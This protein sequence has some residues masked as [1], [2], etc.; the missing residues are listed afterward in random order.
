MIQ[1][2]EEGLLEEREGLEAIAAGFG[3]SLRQLRRIVQQE[4]GVSPLEL[5]Q[6]RRILL[7]KQLLIETQLPVT[8]VAYTSGR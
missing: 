8:D 5:K 1:S 4:L 2:I 7:A 6:T 3:V